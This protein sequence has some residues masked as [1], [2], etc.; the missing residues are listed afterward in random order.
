[1]FDQHSTEVF[2]MCKELIILASLLLVGQRN[3][4]AQPG[5]SSQAIE[6]WTAETALNVVRGMSTKGEATVNIVFLKDATTYVTLK[7]EAV[8]LLAAEPSITSSPEIE[9]AE[10]TCESAEVPMTI[11]GYPLEGNGYA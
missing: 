8:P 1:M 3:A 2:M 10:P 7:P 4:E 11:A 5:P 6:N 9:I